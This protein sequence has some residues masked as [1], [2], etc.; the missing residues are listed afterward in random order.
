MSAVAIRHPDWNLMESLR[1][2]HFAHD[3]THLERCF[4]RIIRE[5]TTPSVHRTC[6][7]RL[8]LDTLLLEIVRDIVEPSKISSLIAVHPA[9][10]KAL[11]LLETRF[12][13]NWSL[14]ELSEEVGIS[15]S[16]LAELFNL[17]VGCSVHKF[18]NRVR[19]RQA[20]ALLSQSNLS[21]GEVALEC[22]F[23]TIQR[24]SRI[25][26]E[27]NGQP[28]INFRRRSEYPGIREPR[29]LSQAS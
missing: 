18:L 8:A 15:R 2:L 12:K 14:V 28:A 16:R 27:V 1:R 7:L 4:L 3:S 6:G 9:I 10:A 20:E 25:F 11:G 13:K 17:E 22:W 21:I 23:A 24:F 5:A 19:V 29:L 26:K